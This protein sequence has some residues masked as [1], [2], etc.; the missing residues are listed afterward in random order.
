M[1]T[2]YK[3]FVRPQ[4]Q[5]SSA[6]CK[7]AAIL[8][9]GV[10]ASFAQTN[11]YLYTGSK[12]NITLSAGIYNITAY[13]AQGGVGGYMTADH[14]GLGAEM[15]GVFSF[16]S[17][18]TLTLLVGGAGTTDFRNGG[19]GGGG[20]SFVINNGS[21]PLV[22]AG[23]G[24]GG[25]AYNNASDA[26]GGNGLISGGSGVGG[27]DG[28]GYGGGGGGGYNGNG[29]NGGGAYGGSGAGSSFLNGGGGGNADG[30]YGGGGG[31]DGD[32]QGGGGGGGGGYS[33]G[34]G[35]GWQL[36]G[37]GGS[38]YIDSSAITNL[39]EISGIASP[40]GSPNGEIIISSVSIFLPVISID[41]VTNAEILTWSDPTFSLQT[42]PNINGIF[43]N[44]PGA[45]SP[46]TNSIT[47][48]QQFFRLEK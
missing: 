19:G 44:I 34:D 37:A 24:G 32:I 9:F 35:G 1:K 8:L 6:A 39:A 2:K 5:P 48:P 40:I 14:G 29:T 23:G 36:G 30:G 46:Y 22:I 4:R 33:G 27:N 10:L 13:G 41:P 15:S 45:F 17:M 47:W 12:T 21:T 11:M 43:T 25:G 28:G 38:S 42:A 18:T 7:V 20:G 16:S 31:G 3:S 26:N